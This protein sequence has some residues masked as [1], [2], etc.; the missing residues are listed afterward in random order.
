MINIDDV[1]AAVMPED[2]TKVTDPDSLIPCPFSRH[3]DHAWVCV[4]ILRQTGQ[5]F[6]YPF[7]IDSRQPLKIAR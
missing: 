2:D 7:L 6:L 5:R 4:R 3:L 1:F